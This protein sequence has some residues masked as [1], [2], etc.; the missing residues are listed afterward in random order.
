MDTRTKIVASEEA[1]RLVSHGATVVSGYFDP[2]VAWH[3][4]RLAKVKSQVPNGTKLLVTIAEPTNP[5]LANRAR[6]ELVAALSCVDHVTEASQQLIP[7]MSLEVE[8]AAGHQRLVEH[9]HR[10][11]Q[12]AN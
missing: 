12:A 1:L 7:S 6:A 3:A 8:D 2:M 10:R 9:V 11:Q 5:I 4:E